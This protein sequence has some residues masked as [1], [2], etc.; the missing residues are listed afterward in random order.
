MPLLPKSLR[1]P[2]LYSPRMVAQVEGYSPSAYK[3]RLIADALALSSL[4]TQ[5]FEPN[6]VS[7][8]DFERV[9]SPTFV[10]G[11][12]SCELA[13]GFG[14][15]DPEVVKTLPY[16]CGSLLDAARAATADL[17][18]ASLSSG[19]HHAGYA[20]CQAFCTFNGL[21]IAA[22][23]LLAEGYAQ[24]VAVVDADMHVGDGTDDIL[25]MFPELNAKILHISL[26]RKYRRREHA[27]AYLETMRRIED[28]FQQDHPDVILYQAGADPH[29]NDPLGGV[30]ISEELRERDRILFRIAHAHGIPVAWNLAGGYQRTENGGID[31]VVAIHMATFEEAVREYLPHRLA[32]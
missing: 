1:I 6:P 14:D 5:I 17:P 3:P 32:L 25:T 19:F 16:T 29:V 12:L 28:L 20:C 21:M 22:A 30:L 4:P 2:V 8:T 10:R 26:G 11:I 7:V 24:R 15:Q 27:P 13:N 31:P 18:A 23:A 9:H